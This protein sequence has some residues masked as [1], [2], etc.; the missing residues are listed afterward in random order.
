MTSITHEESNYD[1]RY[2]GINPESFPPEVIGII[3]YFCNIRE[4]RA[5]SISSVCLSS[6]IQRGNALQQWVLVVEKNKV[7]KSTR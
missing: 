5:Q 7:G 3:L 6:F 2:S 1:L 4:V